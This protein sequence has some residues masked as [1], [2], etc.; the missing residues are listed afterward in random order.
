MAE[1]KLWLAQGLSVPLAET[2]C[3]LG[4]V[5]PWLMHLVAETWLMAMLCTITASQM[6]LVEG[7][8]H[9][10]CTMARL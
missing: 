3:A 5:F 9:S 6:A 4:L 8:P 2:P 1:R 10:L 7:A